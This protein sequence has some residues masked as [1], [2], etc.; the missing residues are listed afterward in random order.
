[1]TL[2]VHTNIE[3]GVAPGTTSP[4]DKPRSSHKRSDA[5]QPNQVG[6]VIAARPG[7]TADGI[8]DASGWTLDRVT[9]AL[10]ELERRLPD[11]GMRLRRDRRGVTV[12]AAPV[13]GD[14]TDQNRVT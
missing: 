9:V 6:A 13:Y 10:D 11:V 1:M 12:V 7:S 5:Y 3:R 8:A 2:T 4:S 14:V